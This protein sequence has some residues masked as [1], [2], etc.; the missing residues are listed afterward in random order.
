[1]FLTIMSEYCYTYTGYLVFQRLIPIES[2]A[3]LYLY[4]PPDS[5]VRHIYTIR[6]Y[7]ISDERS[8]YEVCAKS[9]TIGPIERDVPTELLGDRL[10]GPFLCLSA[11]FCFV[12]EDE[13]GICGYAVGAV[14]SKQFEKRTHIAWLPDLCEKYPIPNDG[15]E[16]IESDRIIK[17][18]HLETKSSE[19][20]HEVPDFV[21]KSYPSAIRLDMLI[22]VIEPSVA[23]QLLACILAAIKANGK[24]FISVAIDLTSLFLVILVSYRLPWSL[25]ER[26]RR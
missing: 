11:E 21:L 2:A 24:L 7:L 6:P 3:D 17:A 13:T 18:I 23:K 26:K 10:V 5:P 15:N 20:G 12:V 8:I 19:G 9:Q 22:H 4:K 25:L 16:Q 14:D 1:M